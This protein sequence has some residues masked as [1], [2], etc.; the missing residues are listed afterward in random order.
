M[1]KIK[2]TKKPTKKPTTKTTGGHHLIGAHISSAGGAFNAPLHAAEE[3]CE[4]F[5]FF[6]RS[7][8][9][10]SAPEL[11]PDIL[12]QFAVNVKQAHL[13]RWYL[14]APYFVNTA[15][16]V[17]RNRGFT[18]AVLRQ[19]LERGTT[20]GAR[21]LMFHPGSGKSTD[22]QVAVNHSI[23]CMNTILSK[24]T[25]TCA[26]LI[27][28]AAGSGDVV[29]AGLKELGVLWKGI[30]NKTRAG[31][32]LDVQHA[33]ASGY[34]WRTAAGLDALLGEFDD[35]IGLKN[36]FVIHANDSKVECNSRRDRH[37]HIS[38][39]HI[40]KEAF[41]RLVNHPKLKHVDFICETPEDKRA[42]DVA[43]LQ[44]LRKG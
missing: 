41:G 27:E 3:R 34:D 4:V 2:V 38:D 32:C 30:A 25:G 14:H 19:E 15:S 7:P 12:A 21:G 18:V 23:E 6:S 8:Q 42:E 44:K 20:L 29:G 28:N 10:G 9:G 11:T 1:P 35:L 26:L 40:G 24:Y 16:P 33:F 22:R 13:R 39:G 17:P 5:Q 37:Q 43:L 36:L 31:I